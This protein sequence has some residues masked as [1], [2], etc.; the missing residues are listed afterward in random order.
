MQYHT[1]SKV[2]ENMHICTL[3]NMNNIRTDPEFRNSNEAMRQRLEAELLAIQSLGT[4]RP[5]TLSTNNQRKQVSSTPM[6]QAQIEDTNIRQHP[7]T[8]T[9][10]AVLESLHETTND[11]K[12]LQNPGVTH[13]DTQSTAIQGNTEQQS[14]Q[15][16]SNMEAYP[17]LH[18]AEQV[19]TPLNEDPYP[20]LNN[21][22]GQALDKDTSDR[23]T[24]SIRGNQQENDLDVA[25]E[26]VITT[27]STLEVCDINITTL[28]TTDVNQQLSLSTSNMSEDTTRPK[29]LVPRC[30]YKLSEIPGLNS[31]TLTTDIDTKHRQRQGKNSKEDVDDP[32]NPGCIIPLHNDI[33]LYPKT[34]CSHCKWHGIFDGCK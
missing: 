7:G 14:A 15:V 22:N 25:D 33:I 32:S 30:N 10:N 17:I 28:S 6:F 21:S 3:T 18:G 20:V 12:Q 8:G 13:P 23:S 24:I 29:Q 34:K 27:D 31:Q 2:M 19:G 11:A 26:A 9:A 5:P 4:N 16:C 1:I